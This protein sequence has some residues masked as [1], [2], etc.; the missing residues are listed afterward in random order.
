MTKSSDPPSCLSGHDRESRQRTMINSRCTKDEWLFGLEH[1][2]EASGIGIKLWWGKKRRKE[3]KRLKQIFR[4]SSICPASFSSFFSDLVGGEQQNCSISC[5]MN[6]LTLLL[7]CWTA[8]TCREQMRW[9]STKL[10]FS[11]NAECVY[12][13]AMSRFCSWSRVNKQANFEKK[14]LI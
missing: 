1:A 9:N 6:Q 13:K 4:L 11:P 5:L 10:S 12:M 14:K 7:A 3:K 2:A 8:T